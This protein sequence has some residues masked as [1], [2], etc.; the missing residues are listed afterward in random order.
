MSGRVR[1]GRLLC[2]VAGASLALAACQA[3]AAPR[4]L[5]EAALDGVVAGSAGS[6]PAGAAAGTNPLTGQAGRGG[7]GGEAGGSVSPG[8]RAGN[9]PAVSGQSDPPDMAVPGR[10]EA[11]VGH[12]SELDLRLDAT[13]R[14]TDGTQSEL[15]ALSLVNASAADAASA[16]NVFDGDAFGRNGSSLLTTQKNEILQREAVGAELGAFSV[17]GPTRA[18]RTSGS[19]RAGESSSFVE[20]E[21]IKDVSHLSR[22][23]FSDSSASVPSFDPLEDFTLAP[24]IGTT[25]PF[26]IPGFSFDLTKS[27]E[28]NDIVDIGPAGDR[29]L[30][31]FGVKADVES[32]TLGIPKITFGE[33]RFEGDDLVVAPG[34]IELPAI[35]LGDVEGMICFIDCTGG[36]IEFDR[37]E[38][39]TLEFPIPEQRFEGANPFKDFNIQLGQGLAAAGS[40]DFD[41]KTFGGEVSARLGFALPDFEGPDFDITLVPD[42]GFI[43]D[44]EV[45]VGELKVD[46]P[47]SKILGDLQES[48]TVSIDLP[49]IELPDLSFEVELFDVERDLPANLLGF[50]GHFDGVVCVFVRDIDCGEQSHSTTESFERIRQRR[51]VT[52]ATA[53][54]FEEWSESRE[55]ESRPG[56]ELREAEAELIAMSGAEARVND[57]SLVIISGEAQRG[58]RAMNVANVTTAMVGSAANVARTPAAGGSAGFAS[59]A[60]TQTNIFIQGFTAR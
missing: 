3:E 1:R 5:S 26:T 57:Y 20:Q 31:T 30:G 49:D 55:Q 4:A 47:A 10:R 56:A 59:G 36:T 38:A 46:I 27:F 11:I 41:F 51:T 25:E 50:S 18:I 29:S 21:I 13:V 15:R 58:L 53:S 16:L 32:S 2:G 40:G 37:V 12:D 19:F 23:Q 54:S 14:V 28:I 48:T 34:R 17:A 22:T 43:Q 60:L 45:E 9:P 35:D 7:S 44:F 52:T 42:L 6:S 8:P 39:T 24:S 33:L